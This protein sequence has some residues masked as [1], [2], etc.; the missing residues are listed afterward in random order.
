[1]SATTALLQKVRSSGVSD[2]RRPVHLKSWIPEKMVYDVTPEITAATA[3]D[4]SS[5]VRRQYST[6]D[7][8]L[9]TP[10]PDISTL[11]SPSELARVCQLVWCMRWLDVGLR[12]SAVSYPGF[13]TV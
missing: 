2:G 13:P 7:C 1:M 10:D 9:E 4:T 6:T 3:I 12:I 11:T 5:I 8:G